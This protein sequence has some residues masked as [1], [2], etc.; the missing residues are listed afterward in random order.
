MTPLFYAL[1]FTSIFA[2]LL[3]WPIVLLYGFLILCPLLWVKWGRSGTNVLLVVSN[4]EEARDWSA[5]I[6]PLVVTK[7]VLLDYEQVDRWPRWSVASQLFHIFGP[8]PIPERFMRYSLP[9]AIVVRQWRWPK[10]FGFGSR[11]KD[12]E[13]VLD[14]LRA[15]LSR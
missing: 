12:R 8:H 1:Y 15:E 3:L 5:R 6:I 4:T 11:R 2:F 7:A 9:V 10:R 13:L 14:Q